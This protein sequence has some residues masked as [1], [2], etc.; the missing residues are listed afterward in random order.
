MEV[1]GDGA[2]SKDGSV[3][4]LYVVVLYSAVSLGGARN[5]GLLDVGHRLAGAAKPLRIISCLRP[6]V[7]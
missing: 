1:E 7:I 5:K 3:S 2:N 6:S 4:P